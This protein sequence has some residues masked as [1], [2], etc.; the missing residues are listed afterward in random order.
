MTSQETQDKLQR[1]LTFLAQDESNL[2]LLLEVSHLYMELN[3][4]AAAKP[5]L[6]KASSI[7]PEACLSYQAI[8][9]L[10]LGQFAE[11]IHYCK[12]ALTYED[13]SELRYHLAFTYFMSHELEQ[14]WTILSSIKD[15]D[16]KSVSTLLMARILHQQND[17]EQGIALLSEHIMEYPNEAEALGFLSLLY[18]DS[19]NEDLAK[20]LSQRALTLNPSLYDAQ[21]V[22][23]MIRL[24]TQETTTDEIKELLDINPEDSRLWFALGSTYMTQGDFASASTHFQNTLA[25][26][27]EFYDCY[28]ALAWC[29]L[30]NNEI[31]EAHETY[32]N[33]ISLADTL[34]DGWGGL[35]IIYALNA[36][37]EKAEQ[38]I[39][40]ASSLNPDCFLTQIAQ[41]MYLNHTNPEQAN[42]QLLATLTNQ[43]LPVSEKLAL[44][45]EALS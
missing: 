35:A 16:Y 2:N 19:N 11:A 10:R 42:K 25:I 38:L 27:P 32:Q 24:L 4:L 12:E 8:L 5:Y 22:D 40:K 15:E 45:I 7:N 33:A 23:V 13:S 41:T 26:H 28:I 20:E 44:V 21:L 30:L 43:E 1:H 18:F 31:K 39:N 37:L 9:H 34:A 6:D 36:D 17:M 3:D 29:Q 14:A